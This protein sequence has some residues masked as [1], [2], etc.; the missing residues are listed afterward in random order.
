MSY[1]YHLSP[2][3]SARTKNYGGRPCR[4]PAVRCMKRCRMHGGS[5]G[6]G[7]R[8]GNL[9]ALKHGFTTA[10]VKR[11]K[12]SVKQVLKQNYDFIENLSE[13]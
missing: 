12:N 1:A 6:S 11:F 9:N 10:S 13:S 5:K 8:K 7:A 4:A 3:C 2:R